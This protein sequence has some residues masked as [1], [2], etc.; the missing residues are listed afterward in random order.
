MPKIYR[1]IYYGEQNMTYN[2]NLYKD[3]QSIKYKIKTLQEIENFVNINKKNII[4]N[5]LRDLN[6]QLK[7]SER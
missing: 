2:Y 1:L 7:I 6:K 3:L 4:K 5:K